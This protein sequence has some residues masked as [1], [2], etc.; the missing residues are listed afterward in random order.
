LETSNKIRNLST[1]AVFFSTLVAILCL[2]G[3]PLAGIYIAG[4]SVEDYL[5]LPP[6]ATMK[7]SGVPPF[8]WAVFSLIFFL[9]L[10]TVLPFLIMIISSKRSKKLSPAGSNHFP[11]WGWAGVMIMAAGW[12]L[13]W[14][15]FEWFGRFQTHTFTI[16]WIGYIIVVNALTF[17]RTGRSLITGEPLFMALLFLFS[18]VFWWYFEFLNQFTQNWY[19]INIQNLEPVE[20]FIYATLPFSTVL[21]AILGTYHLLRT[22][23]GISR[24][25]DHFIS[26][27]V[28]FP[29]ATAL[30]AG[31][32]ATISLM[33]TGVWPDYLYPVIW[34][35]PLVII[36]S[37]MT[38]TRTPTFL[39][40]ISN[41]DWSTVYLFAL[42]ALI[43]GF[44]WEMWNYFSYTRWE[45]AIP[46]AGRFRIFEM[47]LAGYAGYL[48]FGLLCGL[49]ATLI[50]H[51][52]RIPG[53]KPD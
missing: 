38:I 1:I 6:M 31:T 8:S 23:P 43:C 44:F 12:I 2:I 35:A 40:G 30:S 26:I 25:L 34:L 39:R 3:A 7:P 10:V 51:I 45:Y 24:G 49:M 42:S 4:E 5:S 18:G 32:L 41:G 29:K 47:P 9:V 50:R 37:A 53:H 15:R 27:P 36:A 19:Y 13:A 22:F 16:P 46:F 11:P 48:P 20:F 17:K 14:T 33:L 21:P 28:L 52:S